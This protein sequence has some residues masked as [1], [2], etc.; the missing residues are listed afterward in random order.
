MKTQSVGFIGSG[1]ITKIML[2]AFA[3]ANITFSSIQVYDINNEISQTLKKQFSDLKVVDSIIDLAK[4]DLIVI[5][6]HPPVIKETLEKIKDYVHENT[7][8]L[9]L[10]PKITIAA[11]STIT[12]VK[13]I[14]RLIPNATSY[15]NEG[16]NPVCFSKD[17]PN[18][19]KNILSKVLSSLGKTFETEEQK[20]E[21]YAI[22]SA[23]LPTYFWFQWEELQKVGT[24]IGLN[25]KET[26]DA[27]KET[28]L[29]AI[30]LF[31]NSD[32]TSSEVIDL[33]PVKPLGNEENTI[34]NCFNNCLLPLFEK[35]KPS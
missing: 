21:A 20:L 5:A 4:Q 25:D 24:K 23:M 2:K 26:K 31:Y 11:I 27:V 17:F 3:N 33:I 6:L 16:Y 13:K 32:L 19:E 7:I 28:L 22:I 29:S 8:I 12:G 9:S 18:D 14:A 30:H 1:R 10:A 34:K 15:I 35:I